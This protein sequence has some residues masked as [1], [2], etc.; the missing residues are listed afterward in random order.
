MVIIN[1]P[2]FKLGNILK[3]TA[4]NQKREQGIFSRGEAKDGLSS[5]KE[6]INKINKFLKNVAI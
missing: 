6:S 1:R 5:R 2:Q 4:P 3:R